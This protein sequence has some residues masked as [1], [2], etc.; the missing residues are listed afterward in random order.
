M[1]SEDFVRKFDLV[2]L[3]EYSKSLNLPE[4]D[5]SFAELKFEI[6][7]DASDYRSCL[8]LKRE[9]ESEIDYLRYKCKYSSW[10]NSWFFK[11]KIK[12]YADVLFESYGW[13]YF[14]ED[15]LVNKVK[16]LEEFIEIQ[17]KQ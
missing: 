16:K 8:E 5:Y 1:K 14:Y 17:N 2:G 7:C 9:I 13:L 10:Y 15:A 11:I 4:F 6:N 12:K 3:L